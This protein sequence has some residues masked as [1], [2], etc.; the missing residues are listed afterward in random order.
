MNTIELLKEKLGELIESI[1]MAAEQ[2]QSLN[3]CICSL[4]RSFRSDRVFPPYREKIN[5]RG[6]PR[7]IYWH[8]VR[9][10]PQRRRK[11]P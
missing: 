9:S 1:E 6:Y 3:Y 4:N 8:R 7:R 10:N 11:R 2:V 5:P